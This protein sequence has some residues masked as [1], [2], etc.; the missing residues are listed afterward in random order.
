[1]SPFRRIWN[2]IRRR[3]LDEELREEVASHLA[4]IEEEER[5]NGLSAEQAR[6]RAL[7]RFGSPV[8]SRERS[9]E[10]IV[11]MWLENLCKEFVFAARRLTRS[12]AFTVAA[13]LTLTLAIGANAAIFAVVNR[14]ILNPL[15]FADS[16]RVVSLEDG[17]PSR[18]VP[19]GFNSLTT[20]LYYAYL[21]R[22]HSLESVALYR[23]EDRAL[24]GQGD[25]E[26]VLTAR[27]TPSLS[28]VLRV[29]PVIGRWFTE[30][31]GAPGGPQVTLL[32]YSLWTRRY[33]ADPNILG[34]IVALDGVS[35]E[36][37]G[38]LPVWFTFPN[39]AVDA[40]TPLP[41][42]RASATENYSFTGVARLRPGAT[43]SE[44]GAELNQLHVALER[45]Y[46]GNGYRQLV[47]APATLIQAT[48][49]RVSRALWI[50]LASVG[51]V[52][53]VA[54][55]NVANLFLVR[56][57]IRQRE[58]MLRSALGADKGAIARYF[59]CESLLLSA[60]GGILGFALAW[61]AI[62][63]LVAFG[64]ANL[65]RLNE[66]RL[67][68]VALLF[69]LGLVM[70]TAVA[71][72]GL[73]LLRS[74]P[75]AAALRDGGR[76]GTEGRGRHRTRQLLM[77]G[78]VSLALVLLVASGLLLRS[79]Q[80]LRAVNPNF[81]PASALTFR[82]GLPPADYPDRGRMAAA[83]A[84]IIDELSRLPGVRVV[85]AGTC[86]PLLEGC[87]Q[88]GAL[89][90]EGQPMQ[91][92][93]QPPIVLR[94]AVAG[95]FFETM[96][97]RIVRGRSITRG[98]IDRNEP[99]AVITESLAKT[100]FAG[101]D[102]IGRHVRFGNRPLPSGDGGWLTVAGVVADTPIIA[103][104]ET[105]AL[106]QLYMPIFSSRQVPL[107]PRT[108][109]MTF[110]VKT[111]VP[112]AGLTA[113]ARAAAARVDPKLALAQIRTLQELLDRSS[114]QLAFTMVLVGIA[115]AIALALGLIGIYGVMSYIVSQRT[116]EIGVRLALGA[117]PRAVA[118]MIVKEGGL[119]ALTGIAVGMV[120]AFAGSRL[121]E[122]VLYG[123]SSHDP[124]VF[125]VATLLLLVVAAFA[126]WIPARRAARLS[127]LEALRTE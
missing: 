47:S 79:F 21:E 65:P 89:F 62:R 50:L 28:S 16:A 75:I 10:A 126:C 116:M 29:A 99:I 92:G 84:A 87:N 49:G 24:T 2:A 45:E 19:F 124:G 90:I 91:P 83:H 6:R 7:T 44:A 95:G 117:A 58:V 56:S 59:L 40:W 120:A 118:G 86:L 20:Q 103:L 81:D 32:S 68:A 122:S 37:V 34:R 57:E 25:P 85:S 76:G 27:A 1:M 51:L 70:L 35:T 33:G 88:G 8:A 112:P 94:R 98:D 73:P 43:V 67:D 26:R 72:G 55:A 13:A 61:G 101:V 104:G 31:E 121:V 74:T 3:R 119:V 113:A 17:M 52:L 106:P 11:A 110:V 22:A 38:V 111:V 66:V 41:L 5:A 96:G 93:Q 64:P 53:L 108:D 46:P 23:I 42:T 63:L 109:A 77:G 125:A 80:E 36:V 30:A 54:C 71:F 69:T 100:A 60:A 14:V 123:V 12:P 15:P 114:S 48:I 105:R 9:L 115:A 107:P 97:M 39:A 127:P 78:Q 4:L 18:N 82:I 102:P